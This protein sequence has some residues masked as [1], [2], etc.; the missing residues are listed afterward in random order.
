MRILHT[1]SQMYCT[2]TYEVG[3]N[4]KTQNIAIKAIA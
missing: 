1:I 3:P 2:N 4:I